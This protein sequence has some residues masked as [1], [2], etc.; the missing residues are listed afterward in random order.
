M[1]LKH[2]R[3]H[4]VAVIPKYNFGDQTTI[5]IKYCQSM[6][7]TTLAAQFDLEYYFELSPDLLCIAGYDGYFKKIN[8]SVSKTLGYSNEEL[9][10]AP[11]NSFVH[12]HDR[13]ITE[14]KRDELR[15]GNV[16]LQFENRYITKNG[17][18][19]WLSWTSIP[20]ERDKMVFAIAKNITYK[21]E[22]E[23]Y[24]RVSAIL[25][26]LNEEQKKRFKTTAGVTRPNVVEVESA[27]EKLI[28]S[29]RPS[30][31][32]QEWLNR[33]EAV[34][35]N[36]TGKLDLNLRF[37]GD[38]LA[39]SERQLFRQINRIL[40]ITPNKLVRIIRLRLAWEAIASGKYRT[41]VE[42]SNIAGYSSRAHFKKLFY[43]VYGIDVAE[44]L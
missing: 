44:L 7:T 35:R 30:R 2:F 39:V 31:L 1:D 20:I 32:D 33:F 17:S 22:L 21:K 40:G 3:E 12:P 23:E 13:K 38:Q 36:H 4:D 41:I 11:I 15:N 5:W 43:E 9:F 26:K 6:E 37:I 25:A 34:V 28:A 18:I 19:V 16:L 24:E 27:P 14:Q 42:I 8:P 10:A 29:D